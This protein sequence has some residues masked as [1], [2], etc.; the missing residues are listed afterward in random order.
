MF[1]LSVSVDLPGA[2]PGADLEFRLFKGFSTFVGE[3]RVFLS[4]S[5]LRAM[6]L[7]GATR[8]GVIGTEVLTNATDPSGVG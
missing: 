3:V 8:S 1:G 5:A 4:A 6:L 7:F 2:P